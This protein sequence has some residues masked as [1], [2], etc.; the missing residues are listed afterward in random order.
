MVNHPEEMGQFPF[1][2]AV[3]ADNQGSAGVNVPN[4][5]QIPRVESALKGPLDR[6][7]TVSLVLCV[8][9]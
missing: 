1:P 5:N 2:L 3:A 8:L 4:V 6:R 9:P 7:Q